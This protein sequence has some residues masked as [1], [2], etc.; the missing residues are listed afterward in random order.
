MHIEILCF[1]KTSCQAT[2]SIETDYLSRIPKG[3]KITIR[4]YL[5]GL[6]DTSEPIELR[7]RY[8]K[9]LDSLVSPKA[10][11]VI[12]AENGQKQNSVEFSSFL[13]QKMQFG[14]TSIVLAIAGPHGWDRAGIRKDATSLSLSDFTMPSHL[15]RLVLIEQ[16]YRATTI[17]SGKGYHK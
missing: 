5:T 15:A 4:E 17:I 1:F 13:H 9:L 12:L 3:I 6:K 14:P 11:L 2:R 8:S 10:L 7:K 16:L